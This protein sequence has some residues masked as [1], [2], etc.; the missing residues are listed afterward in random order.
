[1]G[2]LREITGKQRHR[3]FVYDANLAILA[4]GTENQGDEAKRGD[5]PFLA[6]NSGFWL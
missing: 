3:L 2:M 4:E 1:M 6:A 5:R